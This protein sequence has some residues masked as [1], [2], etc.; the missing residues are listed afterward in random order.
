VKRIASHL[1]AHP[2]LLFSAAAGLCSGLAS[3]A[4]PYVRHCESPTIAACLIGWNIG[5]WFYLAWTAWTMTHSDRGH[6]MRVAKAQAEGAD[7]MVAIVALAALAS[8]LAVVSEL[9]AAKHANPGEAW[10]HVLFTLV[11]VAGSW[12]LL[13]TLFTLYYASLFHTGDGGPGGL[14]FPRAGERAFEPDYSDFLY[15]SFTIAVASQTADVAINDPEMR[16]AVLKHAVLSFVFN[17][18]ILAFAINMAA[19][20]L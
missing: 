20:L 5:A 12:L 2:H 19:S 6:L 17:T 14:V 16:R 18:A 7:T 9:S 3:I 4:L 11:T 13:P 1:R 15:F 10:P 8:L